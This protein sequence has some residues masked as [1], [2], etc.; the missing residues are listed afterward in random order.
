MDQESE[1]DNQDVYM[2]IAEASKKAML[3]WIST[4]INHN[5]EII[6]AV[7]K[8]VNKN[9]Y[10]NLK[11]W[12]EITQKDA[13]I[14]MYKN[15]NIPQNYQRLKD[16]K[17]PIIIEILSNAPIHIMNQI[18]KNN[19]ILKKDEQTFKK[20]IANQINRYII[21]TII[22]KENPPSISKP[23]DNEDINDII[24]YQQTY[25]LCAIDKLYQ[26]KD[27]INV[28]NESIIKEIISLN[29]KTPKNKNPVLGNKME[30]IIEWTR[31]SIPAWTKEKW[32]W[33]EL[34]IEKA[35]KILYE[36]AEKKETNKKRGRPKKEKSPD[37]N[38]TKIDTYIDLEN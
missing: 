14:R 21:T 29:I 31:Q 16:L 8:F 33:L 12:D 17:Y 26:I 36:Q 20:A 6:S 38:Q 34:I 27:E 25:D 23:Q 18:I 1:S 22:G 5:Q 35:P 2:F 37:I 24:E 30:K 15:I 4:E 7:E 10:L 11:Q 32:E 28:N 13:I 9:I 19:I 3:Y